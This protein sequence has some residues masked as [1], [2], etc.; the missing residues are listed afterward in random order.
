M[1]PTAMYLALYDVVDYDNS[2][3]QATGLGWLGHS[4]HKEGKTQH[5]SGSVASDWKSFSLNDGNHS[6]LNLKKNVEKILATKKINHW[7]F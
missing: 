5:F 1:P 4:G 7:H 6:G 2:I 3:R